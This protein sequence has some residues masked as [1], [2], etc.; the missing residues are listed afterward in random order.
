MRNKFPRPNRNEQQLNMSEKKK[1]RLSSGLSG[2]VVLGIGLVAWSF[3]SVI[4]S[5]AGVAPNTLDFGN[6]TV[7]TSV[8]KSV[9]FTN[10]SDFGGLQVN[11][12]NSDS[13]EFSG[14]T[15]DCGF[16][17]IYQYCTINVTFS[18]NS[19][20][21]KSSSITIDVTNN[22]GSK[23]KQVV[24]TAVG[25]SIR[26]LGVGIPRVTATPTNTPV[27]TNTLAPTNTPAPLGRISGKVLFQGQPLSGKNGGNV[28]MTGVGPGVPDIKDGP[29]QT[30]DGGNYGFDNLKK[31][32][33]Y[34]VTVDQSKYNT[35]G[36]ASLTIDMTK[37][38][39]N[40]PDQNFKLTQ[41]TPTPQPTPTTATG[42]GPSVP[43]EQGVPVTPGVV[44][45]ITCRQAGSGTGRNFVRFILRNNSTEAVD[46]RNSVKLSLAGGATLAEVKVNTGAFGGGVWNGFDLPIGGIGVMELTIDTTGTGL[47]DSINATVRGKTT[48]NDF[49]ATTSGF[50]TSSPLN[51]VSLQLVPR[52]NSNL[53]NCAP[54]TINKGVLDVVICRAA[55][56]PQPSGATQYVLRFIVNNGL[57]NKIDI[58]N[59][60]DIGVA[61]GVKVVNTQAD[62]GR[63]RTDEPTNRVLWSN[64]TVDPNSS[65][66]LEVTVEAPPAAAGQSSTVLLNDVVITATDTVTGSRYEGRA[67]S[68]SSNS[69]VSRFSANPRAAVPGKLPSTGQS[70]SISDGPD[71]GVILT[72]LGIMALLGGGAIL[73]VS[74]LRRRQR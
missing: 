52:A 19:G 50:G 58:G 51:R 11:S 32:Y 47:L 63:V 1:F 48:T 60:V 69:P 73:F 28:T 15:S 44:D 23:G 22:A 46:V 35:D 37:N 29:Q 24:K 41:A 18:P 25:G 72:E 54:N 64:Y 43:C 30:D 6:V 42:G 61:P 40:A 7:G 65:A 14:N 12:A 34:T 26:V 4:T 33:V 8:T 67:G 68:V 66:T 39:V 13:P 16:L 55:I 56:N 5:F 45:M 20:G 31:G 59:T 71:V 49:T 74:K 62:T 70:A 36:P 27:P 17:N 38:V 9:T 53:P 2:A 3:F 21:P 57:T 10:D